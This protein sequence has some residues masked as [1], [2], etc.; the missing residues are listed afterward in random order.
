MKASEKVQSSSYIM[1]PSPPLFTSQVQSMFKRSQ[2]GLK[3]LS[4][5]A[6][7]RF[8][9]PLAPQLRHWLLCAFG[10][11]LTSCRSFSNVAQQEIDVW[12]LPANNAVLLFLDAVNLFEQFWKTASMN[13]STTW[14]RTIP[15]CERRKQVLALTFCCSTFFT[16]L[17]PQ[18]QGFWS[19]P[20]FLDNNLKTIQARNFKISLRCRAF[21]IF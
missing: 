18:R 9:A 10:G 1:V 4:G 7:R 19:P 2:F 11:A 14:T 17:T 6:R 21:I 12:E 16:A 20:W 8:E 5:L 15:V 3:V 13:L